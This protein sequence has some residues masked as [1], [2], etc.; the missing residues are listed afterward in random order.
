MSENASISLRKRIKSDKLLVAPGVYEMISARVADRK[1]FEA[2]YMTGFGAVASYL[3]LPDAGIAS[4]TEMLDRV[5]RIAGGTST[6]LIADADTG[7]GGLLNIR[8]TVRGYEAAGAVGIQIEDQEFPKKCGHT[9]NKRVIPTEDMVQKIR[10]AVDSRRSDDTLIIARTDSR[11]SLG[12]DEALRRGEAY[13]KAGAD[14][15]FIEAPTSEAEMEQ[16]CR[17]FDTPQLA[18]M[19]DGGGLTPML[20]HARLQEIG[21]SI[22]IY[23]GTAFLAAAKIYE[24]VYG[25]IHRD[26]DSHAVSD[27]LYPFAEMT[28][29]MGFDDVWAFEKEY[30]E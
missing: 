13:A 25:A 15:L 26:G 23:P 11:A 12:L 2:L 10:V 14:V 21:F 9:P 20:S 22:A 29:L 24:D 17:S 1:G 8:E 6:P 3:G 4:Y 7:Y 16:I 30:A 19:A 28:K 18:N 27:N 5:A